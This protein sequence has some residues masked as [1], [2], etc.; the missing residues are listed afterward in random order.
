MYTLLKSMPNFHSTRL[1][2][3][4]AATTAAAAAAVTAAAA[5]VQ[6]ATEYGANWPKAWHHWALFNCG[7]LEALVKQG[8]TGAARSYVAPAV[9][10]FF[11]R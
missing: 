3:L 2:P 9:T 11:R 1:R 8:E 5:A 10:G 6:S 7:L 4:H